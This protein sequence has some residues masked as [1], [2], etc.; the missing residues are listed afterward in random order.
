MKTLSNTED[1]REIL[2]RLTSIGPASQR[3]WGR[4]IAV[5]MICHCSDAFKVGMGERHPKPVSN[6]FS[7]TGM[8]WIALRAPVRWP[9]GISTVPECEAGVGGTPPAEVE[10]DLREL[11]ELIDRFTKQPREYELQVHPI[12]GQL[13]EKEWMRWGYLHMDHHLRQ[14]GA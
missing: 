10:S 5:E 7:R 11:R 14:F 1:K 13:S 2:E 4:M 12:F 8:K 3:Q 9:Q 6:W